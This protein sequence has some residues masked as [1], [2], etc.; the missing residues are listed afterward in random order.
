MTPT[1]RDRD[2]FLDLI[3]GDGPA[4]H[5]PRPRMRK[6]R[7]R[8]GTCIVTFELPGEAAAGGH[9]CGDFNDWSQT[10]TPLER[11]DDGSLAATVELRAGRSYRFR[12][13]LADGRWENDWH[14]DAYVPNGFGGDDSVVEV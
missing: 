14:A 12:Y 11:R 2:P 9:V 7:T 5:E 13:L 1:T 8:N 4:S 10:A 3:I 6:Q